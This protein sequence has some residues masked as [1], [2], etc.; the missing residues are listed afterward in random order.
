MI[1]RRISYR[2]ALQFTAF[3]FLLSLVNGAV[4]LV[5]DFTNANRQMRFRLERMAESIAYRYE[6]GAPLL[7][8][9]GI[10]PN[11]R[12]QVR[13]LDSSGQILFS[14]SLFS[15]IPFVPDDVWMQV[16]VED[17]PFG[18]LTDPFERNGRLAGFVQVAEP[19]RL[20]QSDLP[21]RAALYLFVSVIISGLTFGV[22]LFFA[23]RSLRPAQ[24]M[25]E[26]L[27]QFTQ[28][29]SHE[30]RTP[31]A[32]MNSSIDLALKTKEYREGILSAKE[33][34]GQMKTLVEKLL[35]LARLDALILH[36]E[37]VD[38]SQLVTEA[39]EKYRAFAEEKH[40]RLTSTIQEGVI[41]R[42]DPTLLRQVLANLLTNA[43]KFQ[44]PTGGAVEVNL[45]KGVL[46]VTDQG[47]GITKTALPHVFD[48]FFQ[49]DRSRSHG[50]YG[51][52][53]ALVKRIVEL[54]G[55]NITV[56]SGKKGTRFTVE[57]PA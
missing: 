19:V 44:K 36:Q 21:M 8:P 37:D 1:F 57:F 15:A 47:I 28:D 4:F 22:G 39:L 52:G 6:P 24:E 16:Q 9:R 53:L 18:L 27:E 50:G 29:A 45:Q 20:P 51:L 26:R 10:P 13:I 40:V 32:A 41:I 2:I 25:M 34:I 12:E 55:W 42:G 30:L 7:L 3:V 43:I 35:E 38:L 11:M 33:D 23:R 54:H 14:G 56:E 46:T 48:R 5:A 49:V 31:L 17:Q